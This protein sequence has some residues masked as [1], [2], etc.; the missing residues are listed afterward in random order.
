[1]GFCLSRF[2]L[3]KI[4]QELGTEIQPI[5]PTI[6]KKLYVY[7]SPE[8]IPRPPPPTT[9]ERQQA[10]QRQQSRP[11][12]TSNPHN[13]GPHRHRGYNASNAPHSSF[14]QSRP[15][16][17]VQPKPRTGIAPSQ[18]QG[19]QQQQ[20]QQQLQPQQPQQQGQYQSQNPASQGHQ[21]RRPPRFNNQNQQGRSNGFGGHDSGPSV[22]AQ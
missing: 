10:E 20:L 2:N 3:Y 14:Q 22:R 17:N 11:S 18:G 19:Q 21:N 15:P 6:D 4:E 13:Q 1:M 12:N 5:P 7:D 16:Q 9:A 8:T